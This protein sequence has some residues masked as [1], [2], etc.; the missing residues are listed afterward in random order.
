[1]WQRALSGSGGGSGKKMFCDYYETVAS[2]NNFFEVDVGFHPT[3]VITY[4]LYGGAD[5][6]SVYDESS[7]QYQQGNARK[8][9]YQSTFTDYPLNSNSYANIYSVVGN[10]VKMRTN[11]QYSKLYICAWE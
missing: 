4:A 10:I 9:Q 1:M 8:A 6:Y 3:K 2:V 11:N 7:T 5:M